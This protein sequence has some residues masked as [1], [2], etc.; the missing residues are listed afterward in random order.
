V[1]LLITAEA[2]LVCIA[3]AAFGLALATAILPLAARF[4]LG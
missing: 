1:F 3:A 2:L 4:I